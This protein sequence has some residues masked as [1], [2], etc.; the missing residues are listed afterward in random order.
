[1]MRIAD[2]PGDD[3]Q[4]ELAVELRRRM[5][6]WRIFR[7]RPL[8]GPV[9]ND[10][11]G[12]HLDESMVRII[13]GSNRS[14]KTEPPLADGSAMVLGPP[15]PFWFR[16]TKGFPPP[17]PPCSW[18]ILV[19]F[20]N[21][22]PL[23]DARVKKLY[24]GE[25]GSDQNGNRIMKQPLIPR[26]MIDW[27]TQDYTEVKL[28]NGS[29]ISL[30]SSAQ[31]SIQLASANVDL[32]HIDEPTH[33]THW[34]EAIMRLAALPGARL[35][36]C[37]TDT[38]LRT[39]YLDRIIDMPEKIP[40]FHF[41]TD[42]NPYRHQGHTSAV[43]ELLDDEERKV[44]FGGMRRSQTLLVYPE[45]FRWIDQ[46]GNAI[47]V[48]GKESN[49]IQPFKPPN[50]WTRAVIHDPGRTNPAAAVW[51]AIDEQQ[52]VYA[53]KMRYWKRPPSSLYI[54]MKDMLETNAGDRID[55]WY[56]DPKAA[57]Q[58]REV[59][60]YYVRGRRLIDMYRDVA[61]KLDP[62]M[63]WRLGSSNIEGARKM[64]RVEYCKGYLDPRDNS[65]PMLWMFDT[66]EM[67]PLREEF[68][69]YRMAQ[70]KDTSKN[71]PE[72]THDADNHAIYCMEAACVMP[73]RY[74]PREALSY[75]HFDKINNFM[76]GSKPE[77]YGSIS[78]RV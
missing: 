64:E 62:T 42:R 11:Y 47:V 54:L 13:I 59:E 21:E 16:W 50:H 4:S 27:H 34:N 55:F 14:G 20:F 2:L 65:H 40:V 74:F 58:P 78:G 66:P 68:R 72:T 9:H 17:K 37:L 25:E 48:D 73:L 5:N 22:N 71:N 30:K 53:Y 56:I 8:R 31:Q 76:A 39:R 19:P 57:K 67:E 41:T 69:R 46:E 75:N 70:A 26:E 63:Y 51:F 77:D 3:D 61:K 7:Y 38:T 12:Y 33:A 6:N 35:V 36:H 28:I 10:Q 44:R 29:S 23:A 43:G 15:Y 24:L 45:V 1:M 52:N 60:E 18:W 32:I 49:W